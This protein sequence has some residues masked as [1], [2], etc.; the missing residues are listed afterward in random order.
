MSTEPLADDG[1]PQLQVVND[2]WR[3][4]L[5]G[6]TLDPALAALLVAR[7]DTPRAGPRC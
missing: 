4:R 3:R 1:E 7:G 6:D 2:F 5:A